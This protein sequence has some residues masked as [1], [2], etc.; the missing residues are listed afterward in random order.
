[1]IICLSF[2]F[3]IYFIRVPPFSR[4][5]LAPAPGKRKTRRIFWSRFSSFFSIIFQIRWQRISLHGGRIYL[6]K[7]TIFPR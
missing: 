4:F 5:T 6:G 3:S 1:M 2:L 7:R